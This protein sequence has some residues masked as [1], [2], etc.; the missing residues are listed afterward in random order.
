MKR[1]IL[2][3]LMGLCIAFLAMAQSPRAVIKSIYKGEDLGVYLPKYERA[4]EKN[5]ETNTDMI[6]MEVV[7]MN[8]QN[9][10]INAYYLYCEHRE[11]IESDKELA[12]MLKSL[13]LRLV[14]IFTGVESSSAAEVLR[15]DD[16]QTYARYIEVASRNHHISLDVLRKAREKRAFEDAIASATVEACDTFLAKFPNASAENIEIINSQRMDLLFDQAMKSSDEVVI[17]S[18]IE[19]Y[20]GY[21]RVPELQRYLADLMYSQA[22]RSNDIDRM[23]VFVALYPSHR[24]VETLID[25]LSE[26]EYESLDINDLDAVE[27]YVLSYPEA[28]P[29]AQL[30]KY[31]KLERM[32]IN[33]DLMEIFDYLDKNGYDASYPRIVKSL[34]KHHSAFIL[35]P[36]IRYTDL[37]RFIDERGRVGY[38][39]RS[40]SEAIPARYDYWTA[41][42]ARFSFDNAFSADFV[43]GRNVAIVSTNGR[44]SLLNSQASVLVPARYSSGFISSEVYM[45][46]SHSSANMQVERFSLSG[47]SLGTVN[48]HIPQDI[49]V[50]RSRAAF[51]SSAVM[52]IAA[53]LTSRAY[54]SLDAKDYMRIITPDGISMG[55]SLRHDLGTSA[56][57]ENCIS[58]DKGLINTDTWSVIGPDPYSG[59]RHLTENRIAVQ[60]DGKWGYLD[61]E[62][63][64]VIPLTYRAASDFCGGSAMVTDP[65]QDM[66]IDAEGKVIFSSPRI[67]RLHFGNE[68]CSLWDH[69]AFYIFTDGEGRWGVVDSAA[70]VLLEPLGVDLDASTGLG[71]I[72]FNAEARLE[73]TIDGRK[74]SYNIIEL[75]RRLQ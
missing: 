24:G 47:G 22:L 62:L 59:H 33:A 65:D 9:M 58:T 8:A 18:F 64:E 46:L 63:N 41:S 29:T 37:I 43:K 52:P 3:V 36:D 57:N 12:K 28:E 68:A 40:G 31:L 32:L 73:Y 48:Y 6:L 16:E 5:P 70:K 13:Q 20:P 44:L 11:Q 10:P 67:S 27:A 14:D 7:Y 23:K 4:K 2:S 66:L 17:S 42:E 15:M 49:N 26:L 1:F 55:L 34:A 75:I 53:M 19:N 51:P 25:I 21:Y 45:S 39:N 30:S 71:K 38:W 50:F 54:A 69:Y 35:T 60:K 61:G 72:C 56:Y 74:E